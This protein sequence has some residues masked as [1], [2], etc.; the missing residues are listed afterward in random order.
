MKFSISR[1]SLLNL[2]SDALVVPLFQQEDW[3]GIKLPS[4][5]KKIILSS[6]IETG[7][8][9][10]KKSEIMFLPVKRQ[11]LGLPRLFLLGFGDKQKYDWHLLRDSCGTLT[12]SLRK[13]PV[14]KV[15]FWLRLE[16]VLANDWQRLGQT[17]A[18]G[19]LLG[20][21]EF[22]GYKSKREENHLPAS[23]TEFEFVEVP[24]KL[25]KKFQSGLK[26][27]EVVAD[28]VKLARDL[29]N[30]PA[31]VANPTMLAQ[32]AIAI[33]KTR[34][35]ECEVL[36]EKQLQSL[37][38]SALLGVARGSNQPPKLIVLRWYGA[39]SKTTKP[40]A[41]LGKGITFDSGGISL[42][43]SKSMEEM[44]FDMS[45]GG[46]VI[47]ILK[48]VAEL[49]LLVNVVG[50][51]PAVENLPSGNATKPG[52]ILHSMSGTTIEVVNTDA[53]GRLILADALTYAKQFEPKAIVDLATLTGAVVVALGS[54]AAAIVGNDE[55]LIIELKRSAEMTGERIWQFPLYE[56]YQDQIKS[57][58]AD[59]KNVGEKG[60]GVSIGGCFLAHFAGEVPWAH[61]DIAGVAATIKDLPIAPKGAT[62]FGVR[63]ILAWLHN[64]GIRPD[65]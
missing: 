9:K 33:A 61:L 53:E 26:I 19:T 2:K 22:E 15:S 57:E 27:G 45:G 13:Y 56:E 49:K 7:D 52:D 55:G 39:A 6:V 5:I 4:A 46:D 60:A 21:Y 24:L 34:D 1:Q 41:L 65:N 17:F 20:S 47:A 59:L 32:T 43:P 14:K 36:G 38:M 37:K 12:K 64:Y 48:A 62:G 23:L 40:I 10:A 35:L 11:L 54:A 31:N 44:K 8:F 63:L 18:E 50:I 28:A 42:K 58:V 51:I 25:R 3:H 16:L 29:G 30:H